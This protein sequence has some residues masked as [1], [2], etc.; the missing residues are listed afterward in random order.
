MEINRIKRV[1]SDLPGCDGCIFKGKGVLVCRDMID[2]YGDCTE[3]DE[4]G[5][6]KYIFV[7]DDE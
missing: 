1:V 2:A 6:N 5:V 7:E 3:I 4:S